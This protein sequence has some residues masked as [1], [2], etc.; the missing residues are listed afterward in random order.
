MGCIWLIGGTQESA[1]LAIAVIQAQI[2]CTVTVTTPAAQS[3]Y[4]QGSKLNVAVGPLQ[5]DQIPCFLEQHQITGIL[6]ASHPFATAISQQAIEIAAQQNIPYL[7][8]ERVPLKILGEGGGD[9]DS[10]ET[11]LN[12]S[13]LQDERV[14]LTIGYRLLPLFQPWQG[15]TTLFARILP[16]PVALQTALESGFTP[17]R[18]IALRPPISLALELA[19]WQQWQ[20]SAV[21]TKASGIPGGEEIKRQAATQ[22]GIKLITIARPAISY[23]QQTSSL[24]AAVQFCRQVCG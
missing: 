7:R 17:D 4:P 15:Q 22:L 20:I 24:E 11:L 6:D 2:A 19:L 14:L 9:V 13:A 18:I 21:V 23:P 1:Q 3:L 8:Y 5:A 12:G 10:F 16:S